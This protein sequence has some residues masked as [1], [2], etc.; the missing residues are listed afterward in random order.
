M[1]NSGEVLGGIRKQFRFD[2]AQCLLVFDDISLPLGTTRFRMKG[3][4]G[5]H[6]GCRS[7]IERFGTTMIPR[8]RIGIGQPEKGVGYETF[9]LQDFTSEDT[10][11]IKGASRE[12]VEKILFIL[13]NEDDKA[14][15]SA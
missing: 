13:N 14:S 3:G 12:A 5:G 2:P 9:V 4:Y 1:N 10:P 6:L 11:K 8:L 7:V 15:W